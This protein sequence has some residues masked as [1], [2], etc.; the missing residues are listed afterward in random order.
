MFNF[1]PD[2]Q[3]CARLLDLQ[4]KKAQYPFPSS[5]CRNYNILGSGFDL[6]LGDWPSCY[7]W[8]GV[9]KDHFND[10]KLAACLQQFESFVRDKSDSVFWTPSCNVIYKAL[11]HAKEL[12][13]ASSSVVHAW[14]WQGSSLVL[15][16]GIFASGSVVQA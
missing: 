14:H 12:V 16:W 13:F 11:V 7:K 8:R 15:Q 2:L 9:K 5:A 3:V 1:A 4:E 10:G 6:K